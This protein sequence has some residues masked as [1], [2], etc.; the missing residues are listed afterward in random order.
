VPHYLSYDR[1][2][3]AYREQGAGLPLLVVPG[4]PARDAAY[5][6]DLGGLASLLQRKLVVPDL[7]G[8]GESQP[9]TDADSHRAD[10]IAADVATLVDHLRMAPVDVLAHSAGANVAM[11]LAERRPDL[12]SRLVL[13]TP[14]AHLLGIGPEDDEWDAALARRSDEPWYGEVRAALDAEEPTPEQ[15]LASQALLYARWDATARAH[16]TSDGPQRNREATRWFHEGA[17]DAAR[18]REALSASRIPVRILLGELDP[19]PNARG[20][21]ELAGIFP[22]ARVTV[23]PGAG[24]FPWLD[25]PGRFALAVRDSLVS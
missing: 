13:V 2:E 1:A 5:L 16:A 3:L 10:R 22:D 7:R 23:L 25:D 9:G 11:L 17:Y 18:S 21:E 15:E 20:G 8:T 19:W 12:V 6:G 4:G 24:H 14:G